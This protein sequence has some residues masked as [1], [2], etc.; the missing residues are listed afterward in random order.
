[1][2]L[3]LA[4]F[5]SFF[6][7]L[8]AACNFSLAED[9]TPPPGYV[10]PTPMPTLGPLYPASAP[11]LANGAAIY[12]EKCAACHGLKGMGDGEQGKQL[13]VP[14]AALGLPEV[15]RQASPASWFTTVSQGN[16]DRFMPPFTSLSGQERWDVVAY[17]RTLHTTPDEIE[18]GRAL[19]QA[20]CVD[21]VLDWFMNQENMAAL[22]DADLMRIVKEGSQTVPILKGGLTDDEQWAVV[23]YLRSL[24]VI[25][26]VAQETVVPSP[27]VEALTPGSPVVQTPIVEATPIAGTPQANAAGEPAAAPGFGPVTGRIENKTRSTLPADFKVTLRAFE[28]GADTSTGPQEV[29]S[30]DGIVNADGSFEF[31]DI[32]LPENRIF[33]AQ[34]TYDDVPY[35][36]DFSI[37][38]I[39][40]QEL[41]L[42]PFTIYAT[43]TD[44][45]ALAIESVHMFFDYANESTLQIF[46]VYTFTNTGDKT[47]VVKLEQGQE[48]PFI[49]FPSGAQ[50]QVT[51]K[52]D[53]SAAFVPIS[54]GFAMPPTE[55]TY[56]LIAFA[57]M[58]R[59]KKMEISQP[60][61][62]PI[63]EMTL[64]LPVGVE[65]SGADLKAEGSQ[66]IQ[67]TDFNIYS[68]SG[69]AAGSA[70]EFTLSGQPKDTGQAADLT[71]NQTLLIGVGALG[72]ALIFAGAWLY[73]RERDRTGEGMEE[74]DEDFG[75]PEEIMDA[76]VALD[77]LHRAGKLQ[78]AAY[79][80][81]RAEL[82]AR[83][84]EDL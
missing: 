42:P 58:P 67:D 26:S 2:N 50:N 11:N 23:A 78:D 65:A 16:L 46:S 38:A 1:M 4:I 15:A 45:S 35:Q 8:L 70:L 47:I 39:G 79:Q 63:D 52:T 13:P 51:E 56:G 34:V 20:N 36:S 27:Q 74:A 40:A 19:Y 32:E 81:R 25:S 17:A 76:I 9:I 43:T 71:Q 61:V 28:H 55:S 21:C 24:T 37:V 59:D 62:M 73:W 72:L 82:K 30:V 49:K 22:S 29:F 18:R 53:D 7:A 77:D 69:L 84:K 6:A 66:T 83:L 48:I 14:V 5:V 60:V 3:R 31:A 68:A 10:A 33:I 75:S 64:F 54:D 41:T 57:S 80:K 12:A 44:T